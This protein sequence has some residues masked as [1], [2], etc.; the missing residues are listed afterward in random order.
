[1]LT[2]IDLRQQQDWLYGEQSFAGPDKDLKA[3]G[4]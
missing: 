4:K 3:K 2:K 1:M